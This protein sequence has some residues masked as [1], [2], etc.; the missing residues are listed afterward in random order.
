M[1]ILS[2]TLV[3]DR[4]KSRLFIC[5]YNGPIF[6]C[7]NREQDKNLLPVFICYIIRQNWRNG[8]RQPLRGYAPPTFPKEQK[9]SFH[10]LTI[11][12]LARGYG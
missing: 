8:C 1:S 4:C 10:P 12:V 11:S 3:R 9:I 5:F 2:N 6:M 7:E